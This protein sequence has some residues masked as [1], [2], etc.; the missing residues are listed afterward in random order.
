MAHITSLTRA[1]ND[2]YSSNANTYSYSGSF[3][4]FKE[5][6]VIVKLDAVALTYQSGTINESASPREY[7]V[8]LT[9]KTV[10]IGGAD[11]SSGTISI[12]PVTDLG[13]PTLKAPYT[14]GSA[15][16]ASDLTNNQL[17]LLRKAMEY[18][19]DKMST[20]GDTMTGDLTMGEDTKIVF[21]GA[22]DDGYETILTVTDPSGSDKT[23]TLPNTTG[24]V[25]TTGDSG[26][27]A[28]GMIA[29]DAITNAKI[30]DNALDSEHYTDGS[31]DADH[32]ASSSVTTAKINAD[33]VT[34]AKIADDA[35]DS[36]HLAADSIDAEHYAAGSVDTTAL[37]ADAVTGAKIADDAID[38]E[39]YTD[40]SIDTA[41]IADS[42]V[43]TAKIADNA[44]TFAKIGCEQTT[45]SDTDTS[46]PTSGAVVDYVSAQITPLGGFE[47]IA[48][49]DN[50]PT[51]VPAAGVIVSIANA[52]GVTVN[53]SGTST[54]A[55]TAGN[56]SDNV[57]INNFPSSLYSAAVPN[58]TGLLVISTGSSHTYNFHRILPTTDDVKQLSDD[59]NDFFA[60]YRIASSAPSSDN[61]A[62]DLYY[63]TSN[64][65]LYVYSGSAWVIGVATTPNDD[66]V[67]GAK[68]VDDAINS[69]HYTDG[70]IDT[71]HIADLNVT[72]AKIAADAITG[73]KIADDA[74][75]SEHY[76]DGSV[77]HAHLAADAVDG[78]NIA[79]DS[80]NSEHYVDGSIDTAH[81]ADNQITLA[82]MAGGTDGQIIT[83]DASGDPVAVGPG[84]DGQVLTSTG[85]GS[86][87]AFETLSSGFTPQADAWRITTSFQGDQDPHVNYERQDAAYEGN[88]GAA[89]LTYS[90]GIFTFTSTGWYHVQI[91]YFSYTGDGTS[92]DY[93]EMQGFLSTDS[94]SSYTRI[95]DSMQYN[96]SSGVNYLKTS[97]ANL[98][99]V[100]NISTHRWKTATDSQAS[101]SNTY[102]STDIM[103]TGFILL[104][105]GDI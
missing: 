98:F 7:T 22:T 63:N 15:I 68:I 43:T 45:I 14:A 18:D 37:G 29:A 93:N 41:H 44:I 26:T 86:P 12:Y 11:L 28:T 67:T 57:T 24:T 104:R 54:T 91:F 25:V 66:T 82:K 102:A 38:S 76:V 92:Q 70:S 51:T 88:L 97:G 31:I 40:A 59:V 4:T 74:L 55:R 3:E 95:V 50:F 36:E 39:H 84:T 23:I 19:Q 6:E 62:G 69:E 75:D 30:A 65:T 33:A 27:V 10:H 100:T 46:V 49:E 21:E 83:Y 42:Q 13:S 94:G 52:T 64:N 48:D 35:I 87:P 96:P 103:R 17:Q 2:I 81:I 32:L 47:A 34:G 20:T 16:T 71:A 61:D 85:A 5:T 53:G 79:D 80:I 90:S 77:D 89:L 72:T 58:N 73:A 105:L 101:Q 8:N 78:D 9:D 56:G 99:K 1:H 60:R